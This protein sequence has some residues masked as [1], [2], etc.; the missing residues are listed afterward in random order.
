M[1]KAWV[2]FPC[3]LSHLI[4][5]KWQKIFI[6]G[7]VDKEKWAYKYLGKVFAYNKS[8]CRNLLQ[9]LSTLYCIYIL[10]DWLP[11]FF[12]KFILLSVLYFNVISSF[13]N[14]I[15]SFKHS[16]IKLE[17]ST[18][19]KPRLRTCVKIV[20]IIIFWKQICFFFLPNLF[21]W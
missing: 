5:V 7:I 14:L 4:T 6:T 20:L 17:N 15:S 19:Y 3:I 11:F 18:T 13:I 10:H 2:H 8:H 12:F 1:E 9:P 16:S 21:K